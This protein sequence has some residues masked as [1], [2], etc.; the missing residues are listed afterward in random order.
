MKDLRAAS[1]EGARSGAA[2]EAIAQKDKQIEAI[3]AQADGLSR[4]YREL[5]ERYEALEKKNAPVEAKK[6]L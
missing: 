6:E 3:K 2:A 1:N 5:S 4:E